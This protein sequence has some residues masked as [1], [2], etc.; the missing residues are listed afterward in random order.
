MSETATTFAL[1]TT[2]VVF[3][4]GA[5][6]ETGEHLA[7]LGVTR[8]LVVCDPFVSAS[9]LVERLQASLEAVGVESVVYDRIAGEP[10]EASVAEAGAAA[11]EG[12]DGVLGIGGGSA[13]DTAKLCALFAT[14]GYRP[15][16]IH[17]FD[18]F[19]KTFH[20]ET[21]VRLLPV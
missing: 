18:M 4:A 1:D 21:V 9:G 13:L 14:H 16:T 17:L 10:S 5:S 11:Q 8:A 19:P 7:Q 6:E 3:G 20:L 15:D 2:R 12:Y